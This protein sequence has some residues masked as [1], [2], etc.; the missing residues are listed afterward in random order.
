MSVIRYLCFG[1]WDGVWVALDFAALRLLHEPRIMYIVDCQGFAS[2][3][4]F[5]Y[6]NHCINPSA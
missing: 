6:L 2:K 5:A 1:V 3:L 4:L